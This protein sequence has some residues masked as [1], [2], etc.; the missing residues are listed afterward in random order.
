M[1]PSI[2]AFYFC[3]K[4]K[5]ILSDKEAAAIKALTIDNNFEM[6]DDMVVTG[7]YYRNNKDDDQVKFTIL[8]IIVLQ[9]VKFKFESVQ[10]KYK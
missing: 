5:Q 10:F 4:S 2:Y 1:T 7:K 8:K 9:C 6:N 3:D